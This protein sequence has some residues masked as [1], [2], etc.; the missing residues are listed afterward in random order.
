[1]AAT[2]RYV[3]ITGLTR[4]TQYGYSA[5]GVEVY[6]TPGAAAV[7]PT[8]VLVSPP[9][10]TVRPGETTPLT[11]YAFDDAG[12]GGPLT[13]ATPVTWSATA[14]QVDA[15]GRF[16]APASG[17]ATVTA[18]VGGVA[19]VATVD[20]RPQPTAPAPAPALRNVALGRPVTASS[21]E[22]EGTPLADAVDGRHTT[23]WSSGWGSDDEWIEVDLGQVTPISRVTTDWEAAHAATFRILVRDSADDP[24]RQLGPDRVGSVGET[25]YDVSATARHVRVQGLT[26]AT[27]YGYSL[28]ELGVWSP[29]TGG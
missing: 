22:W 7:T 5:Y 29:V 21:V 12:N 16:T 27:G 18:T 10:A 17:S 15:T 24:W 26:R 8:T 20:V 2:G 11:A 14:G 3:R 23:R 6:G 19:G 4:L 13:A 28:W 25:A 9:A 1:M